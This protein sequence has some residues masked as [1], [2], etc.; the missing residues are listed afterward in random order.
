VHIIDLK[1]RAEKVIPAIGRHGGITL[2]WSP[3]GRYIAYD[4]LPRRPYE[5]ATKYSPEILILDLETGESKAIANG[6]GP[7]WSPSGEWIAF[8]D[9][10]RASQ[11]AGW[12]ITPP[13]PSRLLLVRPD[14]TGRKILLKIRGDFGFPGPLV[15]SPDSKTILVNEVRDIDKATMD[16]KLLDIATGKLTTIVK[17]GPPVFGWAAT[18]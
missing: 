14:G 13:A 8:L 9:S 2:S 3:D 17:G 7:A 18:N 16:I 6:L 15:W 1:T 10:P 4:M 11:V 5:G 12:L